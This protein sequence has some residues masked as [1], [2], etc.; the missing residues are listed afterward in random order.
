VLPVA[1][2]CITASEAGAGVDI[3][4]HPEAELHPRAHTGI[5]DLI[6]SHL[7]GLERPVIVETHSEVLLLRV[8]RKVAEDA[9][10]PED[11]AIYW[12]GRD[13]ETGDASVQK[14]EISE[15]GDV[16]NWPEGVFQEDYEE[17]VAI[18]REARRRGRQ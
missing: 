16:S 10:K 18:R 8:R 5:A 1:I 3:I 12:V 11:V 13:D 6:V 15:S 2:Q 9:L 7:P 4:E 14:V 17:V